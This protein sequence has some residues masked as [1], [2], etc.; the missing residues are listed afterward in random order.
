ML[1]QL[2]L[3]G[4]IGTQ[5][6]RDKNRRIAEPRKGWASLRRVLPVLAVTMLL[7]TA[8]LQAAP[9]DG[10]ITVVT[11]PVAVAEIADPGAVQT[12]Y[13]EAV[14]NGTNT[15]RLTRVLYEPVTGTLHAD[16][17]DL[18][19]AGVRMQRGERGDL[20]LATLEGVAARYDAAAQQLHL[21]LQRRRVAP[22]RISASG[23]PHH[24]TESGTGAVI[25]YDLT[26]DTARIDGGSTTRSAALALDAWA[27]SPQGRLATTGFVGATSDDGAGTRVLRYETR[28]E[29]DD[30]ERAMTYALGD[31]V[32]GSLS[33]GRSVR[34]GGV[35]IRKDF[36]LRPDLIT[37]PL[38]SFEGD[39]ALPSTVDVFIEGARIYSGATESGPFRLEN[40]PVQ[41]GRGT[42]IVSVEDEAGNITRRELPFFGTRNLLRR[43]LA[44]F[45]AEAGFL[46]Q[47]FGQE[48][49]G[50]G[51]ALALSG[52]LRFGLTD[53]VTLEGHAEAVADHRM[54]GLGASA[55]VADR[56]ELSFAAGVSRFAGQSGSFGFA[57]MQMGKAR[58]LTLGVS[59]YRASAGFS[60]LASAGPVLDGVGAS[61]P[62]RARDVVTLGIPLNSD[63]QSLSLSYVHTLR[64]EDRSRLLSVG[65][66]RHFSS[67]RASVN[68]T[69]TLDM[70]A[71]DT[72]LGLSL[73]LPLGRGATG[74]SRMSTDAGVQI[75]ALRPLS[76]VIGDTG[77][78]AALSRHRGS[79]GLELGISR[80][81]RVARLDAEVRSNSSFDQASI[82]VQ[83]AVLAMDRRFAL[84]N[85]IHDG[86]ALVDVGVA[87][88][89]VYFQN[90]A[91]TRTG[92]SGRALVTGLSSQNPNRIAIDVEDLPSDAI[93]TSTAANVVPARRSGV[94]I[95]FGA[96]QSGPGDIVHLT[97]PDGAP[98]PLGARARAGSGGPEGIVGYD[99][100]VFLPGRNTGSAIHVRGADFTC[101][102]KAPKPDAGGRSKGICR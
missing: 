54:F 43:G 37:D 99:G 19:A 58:G 20:D 9:P 2:T 91:V 42:A 78:E 56:A 47:R 71:S 33:W 11:A 40:L 45:S 101:T 80:R 79:T 60:D 34:L 83:G 8:R 24:Q 36:S 97:R 1:H 88:T 49:T 96:S 39:A 67:T 64:G 31:V 21:T 61:E 100:E 53:R 4:W 93:W 18:E 77:Y 23:Q 12:L 50:Y 52:T 41:T 14:V 75:Q 89:P 73:A 3:R 25:N 7:P 6:H 92:R 90:R 84:A 72:R 5:D 28:F 38:L 62:V 22:R 68:L 55:V 70:Q 10:Q 57:S 26:L 32:S 16:R 44:D 94:L 102:A 51:D 63:N 65:Y 35:Q 85:R 48:N 95:D 66:S 29:R 13:L 46:R 87:D 74:F 69:G 82:R 59:A 81:T 15:H 86:F 17:D 76:D 30:P 98:V 27:F